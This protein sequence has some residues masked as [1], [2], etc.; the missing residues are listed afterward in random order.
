MEHA[1]LGISRPIIQFL[2]IFCAGL[3]VSACDRPLDDPEK[4]DPIYL[5]MQSKAKDLEKALAD[6]EK[7]IL[8]KRKELS[9][10]SSQDP[11]RHR[12][13]AELYDMERNL[14]V[15]KEKALHGQLQ[16]EK[17]KEI[18]IK[19]YWKARDAGQEWPNKE[20]FEGYKAAQRLKSA[21]RNWDQRVPKL[22]QSGM[23]NPPPP[24][25]KEEKAHEH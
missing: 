7:T 11:M 1:R 19:S 23:P 12:V 10:I 4:H 21:S 16:L 8:D 18:S 24:P 9:E 13:R 22:K 3:L 25:P 17:R 15:L 2:L 5:D 14:E 20:D 6:Y